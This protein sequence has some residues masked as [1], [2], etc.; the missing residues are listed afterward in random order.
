MIGTMNSSQ[1]FDYIVIGAG[2][3]GC[4]LVHGLSADTSLRVL[5][6]EAGGPD[7]D[8]NI[9]VPAAFPHLFRTDSDWACETE[10]QPGLANRVDYW[11][12]GKT[13]G[14]SSSINAM[15]FQR[16]AAADYDG[17]A[18]L[19]NAGWSYKDVLPYFMNMQNQ[20]RGASDY[21]GVGGPMNVADPRDPNPLSQT[22]VKACAEIGLPLNDDFNGASQ[23]GFGLYQVTQKNGARCSAAVGFLRPILDRPNLTVTTHARATRLLFEDTRCVGVEYS[24]NGAS[25]Q[26]RAEC[27]VIVACGAVV[28]PHLLM[29]SGVGPSAELIEQGIAV[30]HDLPGVGRNLQDHLMVPVAYRC[31]QP[32]SLT[33]AGSPEQMQKYQDQQMGLLTSNIGEAGGFLKLDAAA[34]APDLQF[35][36]APGYFIYHGAEHPGDHGYTILPT[37]VCPRSVGRLRLRSAYPHDALAIEPNGL[38]DSRDVQT[39]LEGVKLARKMGAADAFAPYRGD[40]YLPGAPV[41]SDKDLIAYIRQ[42]ATTIYHPVGTCKMGDD[43]A[44]VDARLRVHGVTG[45]RV[46]DASIM[47]Q[48]VNANTNVP[49]MMIGAKCADLVLEDRRER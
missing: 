21:H 30:V 26:V 45:L 32:V 20:E 4:A 13:L 2:S 27:E 22:F 16:G 33:D 9:H 29:L 28:S 12:R 48:I 34:R 15:I 39:L 37:L 19:G 25:E 5:L 6:L 14:G 42:Y 18:A 17:W 44:V 8:Q 36:F 40:E 10:E 23:I 47:P 11:P 46:A 43:D 7:D 49:C 31:T 38:D 35:H 41:Q 1:I 24:H 3:A